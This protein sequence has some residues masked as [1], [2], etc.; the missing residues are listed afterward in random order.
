VIRT[1]LGDIPAEELGATDYHEHA[2]QVSALLPGDELDDEAASAA[3]LEQ[4][5]DSGFAAMIDPTPVGLGRRSGALARISA[6]LSLAV[7]ASTGMHRDAHYGASHWLFSLGERELGALFTAEIE[8]GVL[9]S[10]DDRGSG[11]AAAPS[12]APVRAGLI[13]TGIDYWRITAQERKTL[14]AAAAAHRR[15]NAPIM[16]HLESGSAAHEVVGLLTDLGVG[17]DAIVLAHIDRNPDPELHAS[18]ARAGAYLG[19]DGFARSRQWP[20]SV[21]LECLRAAASAGAA[22]R[23]LIGGD[24]ARR[25]RYVAYGGM[26]GLRYL[27]ERVVRRLREA[28]GDELAELVLVRNPARLLGRF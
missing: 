3:E 2:F 27:G 6:K 7:V 14:A 1:V 26:P 16:V 24:V 12:G 28:A 25:T 18:L 20:D 15:T 17:A 23:I 8:V 13:K 4:L 11:V 21:L 19:Y 5:R 22:E 9:A 10:D